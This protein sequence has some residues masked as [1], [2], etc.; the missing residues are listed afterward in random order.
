MSNP[1]PPEQTDP[2][3]IRLAPEDNVA[4][5]TTTIEAGESLTIADRTIEVL[6]RVPTGHKVAVEA[7]SAGRQ[8]VKYGASI[9]SATRDIRP[10]EYVH[11]HNLASDYLPTYT[12]DAANPWGGER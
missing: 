11:T 12:L 4:A 1:P 3:L 7:I 2:R 8:V 10:G 9:G 6:D 5:V